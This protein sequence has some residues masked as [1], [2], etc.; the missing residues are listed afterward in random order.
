MEEVRA[1]CRS[2]ADETANTAALLRRI[3]KRSLS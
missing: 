2:A 1:D 3:D